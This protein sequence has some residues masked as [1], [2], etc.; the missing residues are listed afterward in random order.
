MRPA[1]RS[2]P[3]TAIG[4]LVFGMMV[5]SGCGYSNNRPDT[6]GV[7]ACYEAELTKLGR[8]S[9]GDAGACTPGATGSG[10][11]NRAVVLPLEKQVNAIGLQGYPGAMPS[12]WLSP[13]KNWNMTQPRHTAFSRRRVKL[14][15]PSEADHGVTL[16]ELPSVDI[17]ERSPDVE[18]LLGNVN[19]SRWRVVVAGYGL[20]AHMDKKPVRDFVSYYMRHP[21]AVE[22]LT[23]RASQYLPMIIQELKANQMPMEIALV[24]FVESAYLPNARSD[25]GAVGLW[26]F[27]PA[28]G[29]HYGLQQTRQED[30]RLSPEASTKAAVAYFKKLH[31][32]FNGDWL[33]ALAAYNAGEGRVSTAL[34]KQLASG[35]RASFWQLD[36]P[37]ETQEYVPR[38]L[39]YRELIKDAE[40]YSLAL[41][42][43]TSVADSGKTESMTIPAQLDLVS[44]AK[45]AKV[46]PQVLLALNTTDAPATDDIDATRNIKV[47]SYYV[48]SL[49]KAVYQ[50]QKSGKKGG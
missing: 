13:K 42:P 35:Q 5:C 6:S 10:T 30:A 31:E 17:P 2:P 19:Q 38:L 27:I 25:A 14:I 41:D 49:E 29:E 37:R 1:H 15:K 4:A 9:P 45:K 23:R 48:T 28:T 7:T 3:Y 47:P 50:L 20:N 22:R 16:D 34:K 11:L 33:L 12:S 18:K 40:D 8:G 44:L 43:A 24:P 32:M 21:E 36:L 39:A 26:Q 46:P